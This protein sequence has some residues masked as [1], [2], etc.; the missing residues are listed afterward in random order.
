[1]IETAYIVSVKD[2]GQKCAL[3]FNPA[4]LKV[5]LT[6]RLQDEDST[7]GGGQPRQSTRVTTTKLETEIIFDTT[8]DGSDVRQQTLPLK[9][10][11]KAVDGGTKQPT[12]KAPPQVE[13]RW[14]AFSYVG[15]IES[16]SET[17][18]FWAAEGVPLRATLQLVIQNVNGETD[19]IKPGAQVKLNTVPKNGTGTTGVA[20]NAGDSN[21]GRAIAA[22]NGIESMRMTA[23]GA[24][25]VGAG[26]QLQAAAGFSLGASVSVGAGAAAGAGFGIGPSAEASA[27]A[28][29]GLGASA[30]FSAGA[31]AGFAAGASASIGAGASTGF[32]AGASAGFGAAASAGFAS[33]GIAASSFSSFSSA[34]VRFGASATA[35]VSASAGAFAGLGVSKTATIS[36]RFDPARL[37]SPTPQ[38]VVG[39]GTCF[40]VTGRAVTGGSF[41]LSANVS[42]SAGIRF[43]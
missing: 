36:F 20:A 28:G 37:L 10:L 34:P 1:M 40:D 41:G 12:P 5:S 27:G 9:T 3:K 11:A 2:S 14:G 17:L 25:A 43:G 42:A 8:E 29:F 33:S 18:D 23:G 16:L 38:V 7:G 26:V 32:G 6:N 31:S 35:G 24:V 30:G 22:L 13:F 4:S 21:G 19:V 39:S 15:V